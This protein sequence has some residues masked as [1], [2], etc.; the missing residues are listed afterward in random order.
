MRQRPLAPEQVAAELLLQQ[1]DGPR[2]RGLGD[3]AGLGGAREVQRARQG[4]EVAD[5][6]HLHD[7][8]LQCSML[9]I[10]AQEAS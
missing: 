10:D 3:V 8:R 7:G 5:L 4:E 1:L 9:L 6:M 2:Q